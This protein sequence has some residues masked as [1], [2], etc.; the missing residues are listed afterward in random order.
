[1]DGGGGG[2]GEGAQAAASEHK[3]V[4]MVGVQTRAGAREKQTLKDLLCSRTDLARGEARSSEK[5]AVWRKRARELALR[6][7]ATTAAATACAAPEPPC[8]MTDAGEKA[9]RD[10]VQTP[11]PTVHL[12]SASALP[13]EGVGGLHS[14][15]S[16][17]SSP[18]AGATSKR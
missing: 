6:A 8:Q 1:M 16:A 14:V 7:Q 9:G 17:R 5:L 13:L 2:G 15:Q 3:S 18:S 12:A 11:P 10:G 4:V